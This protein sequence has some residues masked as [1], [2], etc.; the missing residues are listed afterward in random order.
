MA[1]QK[2]I[3]IL[4]AFSILLTLISF[5]IL[6]IAIYPYYK[7]G[8]NESNPNYIVEVKTDNYRLNQSNEYPIGAL[9]KGFNTFFVEYF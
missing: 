8:T 5:G 1:Q 3:I 4:T 6:T 9:S 7:S 2:R